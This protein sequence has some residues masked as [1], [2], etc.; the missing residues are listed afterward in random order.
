MM[1]LERGIDVVN[2]SGRRVGIGTFDLGCMAFWRVSTQERSEERSGA[3]NDGTHTGAG[4]SLLELL[5]SV[6]YVLDVPIS[7]LLSLDIPTITPNIPHNG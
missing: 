5:T 3:G 1:A 2:A 7:V 6:L 4:R